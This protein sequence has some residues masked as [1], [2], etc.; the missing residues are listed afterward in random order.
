MADTSFMIMEASAQMP[1]SCWGMYKRIAVVEVAVVEG[2]PVTP[3]MI[4]NRARGLVRIVETWEKLNVGDVARQG[5]VG[6]CAYSRAMVEAQA[7]LAECVAE[8]K[9]TTH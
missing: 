3:K 1:G 5:G 8:N 7:R 4:S 9:M 2:S 6:R